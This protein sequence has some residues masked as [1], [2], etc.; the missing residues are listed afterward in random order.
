[1]EIRSV[2][3]SEIES[4]P[5]NPR[6]DLQPGDEEYEK[7]KRSIEVFGFVEP[8]VWNKRTK[9]LV[10][11]H[12][13]FK[14][15]REQGH[16]EIQCVVVDL[17]L[18]DEKALNVALNKAQGNWDYPKL[19]EML[20]AMDDGSYDLTRTGFDDSEL[21]DLIDW[22]SVGARNA[23]ANFPAM[24]I[25][26][27]EHYDYIV[28]FFRN[29]MDFLNACQFFG[30]KKVES[31]MSEKVSK[32]GLGRCVDGATVMAKLQGKAQEAKD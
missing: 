28:V 2:S 9:T 15:L 5:Y 24:A 6:V 32:V 22:E 25:Q 16:T 31:T 7:I 3:I 19:K 1:M 11:G 23:T 17:D 29:S 26:P 10:G 20:V 13:R 30:V 8:L 21:K 27:F 12:Q 18:N 4:A 14:V